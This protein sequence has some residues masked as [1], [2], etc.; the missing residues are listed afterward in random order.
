[1]VYTVSEGDLVARNDQLFKV[2]V[3]S[4][5][6]YNYNLYSPSKVPKNVIVCDIL[7]EPARP[8]YIQFTERAVLFTRGFSF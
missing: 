8:V 1:L 3:I 4:R 6:G 5:K 7:R 2:L